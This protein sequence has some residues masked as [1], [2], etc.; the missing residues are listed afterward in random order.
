MTRTTNDCWS[1]LWRKC[2]ESGN[3]SNFGAACRRT[4]EAQTSPAANAEAKER[5]IFIWRLVKLRERGLPA[6][7]ERELR[8][9]RLVLE[10]QPRVWGLQGQA[11][12]QGVLEQPGPVEQ[13]Q[14]WAP[15]LLR[16]ALGLVRRQVWVPLQQAELQGRL[17]LQ[18]VRL[19]LGQAPP[20]HP[21]P[22]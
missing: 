14:V 21:C 12:P 7:R 16:V 5:E 11:L 2:T 9:R 18:P 4:G 22:R 1:A 6:Q 10:Q 13:A 17:R 20:G 3:T 8:E 19:W 15:E